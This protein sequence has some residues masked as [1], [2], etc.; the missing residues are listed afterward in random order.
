[1][2]C[3]DARYSTTRRVIE[4]RTGEVDA[5][6]PMH[7]Q[8]H[9]GGLRLLGFTKSGGVREGVDH[10]RA[11]PLISV[12]TVTFNAAPL[13][14]QTILS[15]LEQSYDNVEYIVVDGGST[16]GTKDVIRK[17]EHAIDFW[18]SEPDRGIYDAMNKGIALASGYYIAMLNASDWYGPDVL[19]RVSEAHASARSDARTILYTHF[20]L[21]FDELQHAEKRQ[22]TVAPWKGMSMSHQAMF[23]GATIYEEIG[24]Y[25]LDYRLS[26]DFEFLIRAYK[27]GY[28]FVQVETDEVYFRSGGLSALG[29]Q[30]SVSEAARALKDAYGYLS[31]HHVRYVVV[32]WLG[33]LYFRYFKNFLIRLAGAKN[34]TALR[35]LRRGLPR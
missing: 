9:C 6:G 25:S 35:K 19:K 16:D 31:Y 2:K 15:V 5:S 32:E 24:A 23:V 33:L 10:S 27:S 21:Y 18:M 22:S 28:R 14:E 20:H 12:V 29:K 3:L 34:V 1:M 13:L 8:L 30:E 7:G 26:A 4:P 11:V 17:Y